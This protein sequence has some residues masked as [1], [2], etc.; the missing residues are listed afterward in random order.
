MDR[1]SYTC[2]GLLTQVEPGGLAAELG[3]QPGDILLEVN[4]HPVRDVID[5]RFYSADEL[6]S[7]RVC[8]ANQE[9][10]LVARR[11][12]AQSLG[13]EFAHPTFDIDILRCRNRCEFCFVN[14]SPP[15]M[16]RSLYVK[17]DDYRYSFLFGQFITLTNLTQADW[18]RIEE[19]HLSPLYVSVH[20]TRPELRRRILGKRDAPDVLEQLRWFKERHLQLHTQLVLVPGLNDAEQ[21][22]HSL[23]D[24]LQFYPSVVSVAVVPVGLTARHAPQLRPY[25]PDEAR[26]VLRQLEPWR[27]RCRRE[28]GVTW[29][30]PSDEWYLLARRPIPPVSHY[31]DFPQLE[32]GVGM[33]RQFLDDWARLKRR[34]KR[35]K[36]HHPD[37][38][39]VD[40]RHRS[41][42]LVCGEL[43]APILQ[44][45]ADEMNALWGTRL[46]VRTVVNHWYGLVTASGLLTGR[47]IVQ[48]LRETAQAGVPLGDRL[49]LPRVMFDASGQWTLDDMTLTQL[50]E[51]LGLP[52]HLAQHPSQIA[53]ALAQVIVSEKPCSQVADKMAEELCKESE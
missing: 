38:P 7:W 3:A 27:Q 33:L 18:Q 9:F 51:A 25:R 8:R 26:Q 13:A 19:Q 46:Q 34:L 53:T 41:A 1:S 31:D 12:P 11:R 39:G 14:Q 52:I 21:L 32:N 20:A 44:R 35:H 29:V 23:H 45:V 4:G 17:D 50:Q 47:D 28:L 22:E 30:Y 5:V 43:A 48:Q 40:L 49:F 10:Q 37:Q 42:S 36:A 15:G 16:R 6:V 24:L 2:G